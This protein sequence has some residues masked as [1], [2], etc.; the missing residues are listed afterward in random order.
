M[1]R[2]I[3]FQLH[4]FFGITAGI[5]LMVVGVTGG[6][7]SFEQEI[8]R[9]INP[10]IMTVKVPA[11]EKLSPTEL[12]TNLQQ[13]IPERQINA[14]TLYQ[15]PDRTAQV[16][17]ASKDPSQRRG[18]NRYVDP[19]TGLLLENPVGVTFFRK[20][21]Q[22]HRWFLTDDLLN[23]RDLGKQI[24]GASTVLLVLLSLTGIYLRWPRQLFNL[25]TWLAFNLKR[26]GRAFIWDIHA[27]IGTWV[28]LFYLLASLT[29]LYW[30]YEWYRNSLHSISGVPRMVRQQPAQQPQPGIAEAARDE[31][32]AAGN[33]QGPAGR[34]GPGT[35]EGRAQAGA[36][37]LPI[38][39]LETAWELLTE[40]IGNDFSR[41]GIR[42]PEK[43]DDQIT[44]TYLAA[45][46][47][48]ERATDRLTIDPVNRTIAEHDRYA[49]RP[50]NVRLMSSMYPL[51]AGSYFGMTG[52]ILM[53]LASLAMPLF[54]ITGWMLYLHRRRN[55][56]TAKATAAA[57]DNSTDPGTTSSVL[58]AYA[59][60]SGFTENIAWKSAAK[61]QEAGHQVQVKPLDRISPDQLASISQALFLVS[62]F[63]EGVPPDNGR[64]FFR[65]M[66][67][68][69]P[70]LSGLNY[71][72]LAL[73]DRHYQHYCYCARQLDEWLKQQGG[74]QQ[75]PTVEVDDGDPV[76]LELW[77]EQLEQTAATR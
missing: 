22:L 61:L 5:I 36:A 70:D 55:K 25:K 9:A 58:I 6:M 62:T 24:V 38:A 59:S 69:K 13:S 75:Y 64:A 39:Q 10:G 31:R 2:T 32:Q 29:G 76:A 46:P 7:L 60:Q 20:V 54:A 43:P 40:T 33:R 67:A 50:L 71:Q 56:N 68:A 35:A 66:A 34:S 15:A 21:T 26:K 19:Y 23:N 4:W 73:G 72:L 57:V 48:H 52:K 27:V 14:V 12:L 11:T 16:N 51:H 47:R 37:P 1:L 18:E 30:S 65:A 42:I 49:D 3:W 74:C 63:G 8:L 45:K 28:L 53:M 77:N 44:F 41:I 17:L